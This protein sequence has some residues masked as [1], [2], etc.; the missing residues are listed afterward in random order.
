MGTLTKVCSLV[1]HVLLCYVVIV[2][3]QITDPPPGERPI[4][5]HGKLFNI[6]YVP[7]R[8]K[9]PSILGQEDVGGGLVIKDRDRKV[10][11]EKYG[12]YKIQGNIEIE[13]K[14]CMVIMPGVV[15]YFDPGFGIMVNGTLIARVGI[16]T[17]F[18]CLYF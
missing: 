1:I 10:L 11:M 14:A 17:S 16:I 12:P 6:N 2:P 7:E 8:C 15:M 4:E 5:A 13:P 3:G 18:K 9:N